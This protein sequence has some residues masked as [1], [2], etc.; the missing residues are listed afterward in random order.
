MP[1]VMCCPERGCVADGIADHRHHVVTHRVQPRN[2]VAHS[3][4][5]IAE[6]FTAGSHVAVADG[7]VN[8]DGKIT[9][10]TNAVIHV[11]DA[12]AIQRIEHTSHEDL[13]ITTIPLRLVPDAPTLSL[14]RW[15]CEI[16][17]DR[18]VA[19]WFLIKPTQHFHSLVVP[20]LNAADHSKLYLNASACS[21]TA[22]DVIHTRRVAVVKIHAVVV[23]F[24]IISAIHSE[25]SG[26]AERALAAQSQLTNEI[27][28]GSLG[29]G[30]VAAVDVDHVL[31]AHASAK[32][33]DAEPRLIMSWKVHV[34]GCCV[35]S[36]HMAVSGITRQL[37]DDSTDLVA[38]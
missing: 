1:L 26:I 9:E 5:I 17:L 13:A 37:A 27:V 21:R 8:H 22:G 25:L 19:G 6:T 38:V 10:V 14:T 36:S 23:L 11:R 4:R 3:A 2:D 34:P 24:A 16:H 12:V 33:F 15:F 28:A 7:H 30:K 18:N 29:A 20:A 35:A 32:I 31:V